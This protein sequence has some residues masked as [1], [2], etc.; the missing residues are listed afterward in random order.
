MIEGIQHAL[1]SLELSPSHEDICIHV[2]VHVGTLLQYIQRGIPE[3]TDHGP[4]HSQRVINYIQDIVNSYPAS[5]NSEDKMILFLTAL[6]HDIGCIAGR[7][8]HSE[9]SNKILTMDDFLSLE[10]LISK[11]C[12]RYLRDV[13]R[14][15]SSEYD[16]LDLKKTESNDPRLA[17]LCCL[18]RL[19]DECDITS[20]RIPQLVLHVLE[21]LDELDET[22]LEIWHSHLQVEAIKISGN[23]IIVQVYNKS[24]A[25]HWLDKIKNEIALLNEVLSS[26]CLPTFDMDT[27]VVPEPM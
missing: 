26:H 23:T 7:K 12:Y 11:K 4:Q 3:F 2:A 24:E 27:E 1:K 19:A 20:N 25:S 10:N 6:L 22:A 8:E 14:Y 13:I 18:F 5:V 16:I 9:R 15:H 21:F 17:K